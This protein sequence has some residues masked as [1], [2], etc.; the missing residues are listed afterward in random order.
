MLSRWQHVARLMYAAVL[1]SHVSWRTRHVSRPMY[2][3][4]LMS[5][6]A[7]PGRYIHA[8][9]DRRHGE[10][11]TEHGGVE[12]NR[13]R[14][15][16]GAGDLVEDAAATGTLVGHLGRE[17]RACLALLLGILVV[18]TEDTRGAKAR[19]G[20]RAKGGERGAPEQRAGGRSECVCAGAGAR[21]TIR[22]RESGRAGGG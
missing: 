11:Y 16:G 18:A 19:Q 9:P 12:R 2:A 17:G 3:A 13:K 5:H 21:E 15:P 8:W 10:R 6:V 20:S 22:G 14:E 1:M 4:A 7:G